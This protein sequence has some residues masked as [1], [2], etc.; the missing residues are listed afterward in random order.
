L[1]SVLGGYFDDFEVLV[2]NNGQP[3]DTRRLQP[4][5]ADERVRWFEQ[6]QRLGP[7]EHLLVGLRLARGKYVAVL[8]DDDWWSPKFLAALVP[9]LERHPEAVLAFGD[10]YIVD[11]RGKVDER[12]SDSNTKLWGRSSLRPGLHQPFFG[13]V[14]HQSVALTGCVFRRAALPLDELT[15]DIG[16]FDDI[17]MIYL[18]AKSGGAAYFTP[19]RLMFYRAHEGS[20][21]AA[22]LLST[23]LS[24]IRGR[25]SLLEDPE[26]C[27]YSALITPRLAADH[28]SVAGE[29]LRRGRRREARSH[30]EDAL[31]LKPTLKAL[32]GWAASWVAPS[33]LL[34]RL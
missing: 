4:R 11:Q 25:T 30:I 24:A 34:S 20:H 8:H 12:K 29:Y 21:T 3:E 23:H 28:V 27:D 2:S 18:L 16:S 6:D 9:S 5:I 22:G 26:M 10:H 32:G 7:V 31:R 14:A 1:A 33:L 13:V 15:P 19:E 17:W